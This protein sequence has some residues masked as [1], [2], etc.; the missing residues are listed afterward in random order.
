M[1][2]FKSRNIALA[3]AT[4]ALAAALLFIYSSST[5]KNDDWVFTYS[6]AESLT[7]SVLAA[8]G[9]AFIAWLGTSLY[10]I[11][12]GRADEKG[13]NASRKAGLLLL[14]APFLL[15]GA[16]LLLLS[17]WPAGTIGI[18]IIGLLILIGGFAYAWKK[19]VKIAAIG[20]ALQVLVFGA[21]GF[22][23]LSSIGASSPGAYQNI[24]ITGLSGGTPQMM[25]ENNIGLSAG[26]AQDIENFRENIMDGYLPL[27][28][29]ITYEGLFSEYF[30]DTGQQKECGKL[31]CPSYS[32]AISRDPVSQEEKEF[33]QV[34]LNSGIKES[35]FKRK[36]LNLVI[37]LDIS[38]SMSSS[39]DA[40]Y[41]DQ[42]RDGKPAEKQPD[43]D[44]GK[45]KMEVATKAVAGLL[46]HLNPDDRFGMV[47]FDSTAYLATPLKKVGQK[48]V[49]SLKGHIMELRPMGGTNMS[50]GM[51]MGTELF[52]EYL[53]ADQ[54]EYENRIIFLTDAQPNL[55]DTSEDSLA[56]TAKKNSEKKVYMTFIGIGVDFNTELVEA[57]TKIRGAN[58]YSVHSG[59]DFRK[60]MDEEF[61]YM[62]TPLVFNLLL[63]LDAKGYEIEKVY[64]SPEANEA[65]GQIMKVNTLFPSK[66]EG[67]E[68][69]GGIIILQLKKLSQDAQLTLKTSY[70]DR[71]GRK[72]GD[73]VQVA[74]PD[75]SADYYEN[76]GIRKGIL[77]SRYANLMKGWISDE[78]KSAESKE[79]VKPSVNEQD[80][81][82]VPEAYKLGQW[83]R[84][85]VA[86]SVSEEYRAIFTEFRAHLEAE[87]QALED[88]GLDRETEILD[89]LIG[90]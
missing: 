59:A 38:G 56:G 28:T 5:G 20:F 24:G 45:S 81:I 39:F 65:T 48:D 57:L 75:K 3:F 37:V 10:L 40:Y 69:K 79:P 72:D 54:D 60:R 88:S 25:K 83:E 44:A 15:A 89:K 78:R 41:Y 30:F 87:K 63:T 9:I 16:G 82:A 42:F 34:G 71:Q 33:L 50:A 77:L 67:G 6:S 55:G 80:G 61:E 84:Q 90:E 62:V 13:E 8:G 76:T 51:K 35:D 26:G 32:Y 1:I 27:P 86:L 64:G 11:I 46:D 31:F 85:S 7:W 66:K 52:T 49:E 29:D 4:I 2:D 58:Y 19:N 12:K 47:L 22:L 14:S 74:L 36:K 23:A 73:E 17:A 43:E 68:T 70:E 21:F 53:G 18:P